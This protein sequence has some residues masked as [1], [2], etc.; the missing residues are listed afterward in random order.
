MT[1]DASDGIEEENR[2]KGIRTRM[3]TYKYANMYVYIVRVAVIGIERDGGWEEGLIFRL[4]RRSDTR[5]VVCTY[6][7]IKLSRG[8]SAAAGSRG[9]TRAFARRHSRYRGIGGRIY[10]NKRCTG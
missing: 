9:S 6:R 3:Y 7:Y 8:G 5:D 4:R 10:Y 2:K 1:A